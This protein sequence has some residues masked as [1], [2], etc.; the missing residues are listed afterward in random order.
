MINSIEQRLEEL[1]EEKE[2]LAQF[3]LLD[4]ER[5]GIEYTIYDKELQSATEKLEALELKK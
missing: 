5:R 1:K 3:Q 2:E 4:S